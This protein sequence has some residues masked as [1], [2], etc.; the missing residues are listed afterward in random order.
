MSRTR[1][2]YVDIRKLSRKPEEASVIIRLMMVCNDLAVSNAKLLEVSEQ[3][4]VIPDHVRWGTKLYFLRL[5]IGHLNEAMKV[6]ADLRGRPPML[7]LIGECS[8]HG[9][10]CFDQL[11]SCLKGGADFDKFKAQIMMIRNKTAFHYDDMLVQ[12][13]LVDRAST[14]KKTHSVTMSHDVRDMRYGVADDILST[15]IVHQV[16]KAKGLEMND[17]LPEVLAFTNCLVRALL[18]FAAE[19]TMLYIRQNVSI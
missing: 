12:T 15:L 14:T 8:S 19:F 2:L 9:R 18:E 17:K 6:V 1:T 5:G 7:R 16:W 10:A 11:A 4:T 3:D 13:A